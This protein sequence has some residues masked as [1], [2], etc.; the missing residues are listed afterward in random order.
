MLE[1]E[2][3][4][5]VDVVESLGAFEHRYET[6]DVEGVETKH[7]LANGYVVELDSGRIRSADRHG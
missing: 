3:D 5:S 6:S 4:V 2:F 1:E 7:Y